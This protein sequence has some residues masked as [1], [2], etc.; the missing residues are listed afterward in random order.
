[1]PAAHPT[2][3]TPPLVSADFDAPPASANGDIGSGGLSEALSDVTL[4]TD[5]DW[6]DYGPSKALK[7]IAKVIH[8]RGTLESERGPSK[9][10]LTLGIGAKSFPRTPFRLGRVDRRRAGRAAGRTPAV[11]AVGHQVFTK[12]HKHHQA[13]RTRYSDLES[14]L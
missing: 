14:E 3:E 5:V 1:M 4:A 7:Q 10:P 12:C 2:C 13:S 9:Q 6:S 8:A 11:G